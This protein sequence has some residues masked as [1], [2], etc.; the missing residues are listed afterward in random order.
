MGLDTFSMHPAS[1][2]RVKRQVLLSDV[3]QLAI[4][5]G[6]MLNS[7]DP[8]RVRAALARLR[9]EAAPG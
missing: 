4:K 2:L 8:V 5:V 3:S 7:D 1:L 6:R 9:E